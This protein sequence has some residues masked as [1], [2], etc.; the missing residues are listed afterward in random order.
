[1]ER[2]KTTSELVLRVG[3]TDEECSRVEGMVTNIQRY[4]IHDGP[5]VRSTVFLKGCNLRCSWCCNP[6]CHNVFSE[7]GFIQVLCN[8]CGICVESCPEGAISTAPE[9][10]TISIDWTRCINC[11]KCIK[12]CYRGA[13][14]MYGSRMSVA[15]VFEE[16]LHDRP[17]YLRSGGGVTVSGGEPLLQP[18]FVIALFKLARIAG[19]HTALETSLYASSRIL[20]EVLDHTDYVL[21]DLKLMDALTHHEVTGQTNE[22]ILK[23]A[24]LLASSGLPVLPRIPIVPGVNDSEGNIRS[25]AQ[26][27]NSIRLPVIEIMPFHR[28]ALGKYEGLGRTYAMADVEPPSG[29]KIKQVKNLFERFGIE[30]KV[31]V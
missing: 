20:K 29:Q 14:K 27:L 7:L 16:V 6:E 1:M 26:F 4:C 8:A 11:G 22:L 12:A 9:S 21:F 18:R 28:F 17:I 30:C 31:S 3:D 25:T 23:N 2:Q 15:E 19:I 10:E 13:I 5:G 24:K